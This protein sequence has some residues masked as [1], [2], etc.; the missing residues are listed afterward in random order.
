MAEIDGL[1]SGLALDAIQQSRER[2]EIDGS[3]LRPAHFG[4]S[5]HLHSFGDLR[6]VANRADTSADVSRAGHD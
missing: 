4:S 5:D 3:L 2:P 6:G 1:C